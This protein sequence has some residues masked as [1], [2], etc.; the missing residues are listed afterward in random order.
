MLVDIQFSNWAVWRAITWWAATHVYNDTCMVFFW[1]IFIPLLFF[2]LRGCNECY[3]SC[4]PKKKNKKLVVSD[5]NRGP[6]SLIFHSRKHD[7]INELT[8]KLQQALTYHVIVINNPYA[9]FRA[10][11]RLIVLYSILS[12][13]Q[14]EMIYMQIFFFTMARERKREKN[15]KIKTTTK[16]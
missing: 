1:I 11:T 6:I 3:Q 5:A 14:R 12:D 4:I 9:S 16:I 10:S 2:Y 8:C 13:S 7:A 15:R